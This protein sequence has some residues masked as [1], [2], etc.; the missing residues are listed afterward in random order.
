MNI[1]KNKQKKNILF[2]CPFIERGGIR[3]TLI[4]YANF[5][6][7][8]YEVK[9]FTETTDFNMLN[10]FNKKIKVYQ[11]RQKFNLK[12]NM[13]KSLGL[14]ICKDD[15]DKDVTLIR[16][17]KDMSIFWRL[18]KEINNNS[19]IFSMSDHF[20]PLVLNRLT[21]KSKIIIRT[22][23]IIPNQYNTEEYKYMK[24]VF[25]KKFLM[26]FYKLAN[27]VITFSS[28]N[29]KYFKSLNINSCCI[30]NNFEKQKL[31]KKLKKKEKLNIFSVGRFSFEKNV[32]FFLRNLKNYS[33]INIHLVG[34][35]QYSKVL[36]KESAG[37]KNIFFHGFVK[38]PFKKYL[39][40]MDLLC[41][42]SKYDGTPNV[43]GEAMSHGIPVLAPKNVGL[44]NL[45]IGNDKYGYLYKS[46]NANSFKKKINH[47]IND[48]KSAF[49][50]AKK[51][52]KS[53]SR[54]SKKNTHFKLI[55]EIEKL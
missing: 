31:K 13:L 48:Y 30:Y 34:D 29:V 38:N 7:K 53:I 32:I 17:L 35:G 41:I 20:V 42:N 54:F 24:N 26:R 19:I 55:E 43:M 46:E 9:I 23:G 51:A 21:A 1:N 3:T 44:A 5:L 40:K 39:N 47:I 49:D 14:Q 37:K 50:K 16:I 25:I 10:K 8:K 28:Q 22:A 4:K 33:N 36:H 11:P 6:S 2:Y 27:M 15:N 45:F 52:Y 18:K 12:S